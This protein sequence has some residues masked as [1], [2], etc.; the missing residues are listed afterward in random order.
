M[1]QKAE[2]VRER[3]YG[4]SAELIGVLSAISIVSRRLAG[5]IAALERK[6]EKPRGGKTYVARQ[7]TANRR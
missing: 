2:C 5:R 3:G 1:T 7:S 6:Q 4:G